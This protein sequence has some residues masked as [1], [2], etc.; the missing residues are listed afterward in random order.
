[1]PAKPTIHIRSALLK[2]KTEKNAI[3][4]IQLLRTANA[5]SGMTGAYVDSQHSKPI[6]RF[7]SPS[8]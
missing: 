6:V 7:F 8:K 4:P 5:N 1:M 2:K 3:K